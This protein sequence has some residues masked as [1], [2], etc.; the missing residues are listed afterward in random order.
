MGGCQLFPELGD[1][2]GEFLVAVAC[3][4]EISRR[5]GAEL[6]ARRAADDLRRLDVAR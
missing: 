1:L 2:P 5:Q 4:L 6:L 3:R